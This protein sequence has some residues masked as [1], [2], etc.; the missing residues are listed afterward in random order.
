MPKSILTLIKAPQWYW[1]KGDPIN[2][3][4]QARSRVTEIRK[5]AWTDFL[6]LL[7]IIPQ[8]VPGKNGN[9]HRLPPPLLHSRLPYNGTEA[10]KVGPL[11]STDV[12][13]LC[14]AFPQQE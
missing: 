9:P 5:V 13:T 10:W 7:F 12:R 3:I 1:M 8:H 2:P 4:L 14:P 6:L 11:V